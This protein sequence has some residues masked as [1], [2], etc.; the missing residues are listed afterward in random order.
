MNHCSNRGVVAPQFSEILARIDT[1]IIDTKCSPVLPPLNMVAVPRNHQALP[2]LQPDS[3]KEHLASSVDGSYAKVH[4]KTDDDKKMMGLLDSVS[5]KPYLT[6]LGQI[7]AM[8]PSGTAAGNHTPSALPTPTAYNPPAA[9]GVTYTTS[10]GPPHPSYY[11]NGAYNSACQCWQCMHP[12]PAPQP[13]PPPPQ[14]DAAPSNW[15]A[16]IQQAPPLLNALSLLSSG[17]APRSRYRPRAPFSPIQD[18]APGLPS[19][20]AY[21]QS[22][23]NRDVDR[24]PSPPQHPAAAPAA[25]QAPPTVQQAAPSPMERVP[26]LNS[27]ASIVE[28]DEMVATPP[29][30]M[31]QQQQQ[32]NNS[33]S[34]NHGTM[35]V[36]EQSAPGEEIIP[37]ANG[38]EADPEVKVETSQSYYA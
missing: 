22:N 27:R 14:Y 28:P 1:D 38:D 10:Q 34:G 9:N 31:E 6:P 8:L 21:A 33:Q 15:N 16:Q 19:L 4:P 20:P 35:R 13:P 23:M 3:R 12:P 24:H 5:L 7:Q 37:D 17:R 11:P 18:S 26:S 30:H 29:S 2:T 25:Q 36:V 32:H